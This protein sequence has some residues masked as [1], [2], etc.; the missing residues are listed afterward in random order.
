MKHDRL[1]VTYC[2][3]FDPKE[4][5]SWGPGMQETYVLHHILSGRGYYKTTT[6]TYSLQK[7]DSFIITPGEIVHYY[8]DPTDPWEYTWVNF[9]GSEV[10]FLLS[11]T[12][13][14]D[15]PVCRETSD[16][17]AIFSQFSRDLKHEHIRQRNDGL[18]RIL[19]AHYIEV[20][21]GKKDAITTDNLSLAKKHAKINCHHHNF[22]VSELAQSIGV[23][24]SYLYRLFMEGEGISPS[25][26]LSSLRME[27]ALQLMRNGI[28]QIK[29]ISYSVGYTDPLY[30]SRLFKKKYGVSPKDY[31]KQLNK[32]SSQS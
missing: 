3:V 20:Y 15:N 6:A 4:T 9:L 2:Q 18:L 28:T 25:D 21:P 14:F 24:R 32:P 11:M 13:F 23:E 8:P 1:T 19:L 5:F 31:I 22:N 27:K 30:F 29:F 26:Y 10:P 12:A 7:G 17:S 16:L